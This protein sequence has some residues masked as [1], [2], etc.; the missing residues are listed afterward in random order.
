MNDDRKG[1]K[2][3]DLSEIKWE[4]FQTKFANNTEHDFNIFAYQGYCVFPHKKRLYTFGGSTIEG[5][6]SNILFRLDLDSL[7]WSKP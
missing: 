3:V 1:K 2:S 7:E 6:T 4:I 5:K